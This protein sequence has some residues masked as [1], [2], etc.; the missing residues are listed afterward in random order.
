M[1]FHVRINQRSGEQSVWVTVSTVDELSRLL[2]TFSDRY[3]TAAIQMQPINSVIQMNL[4][5]Q[6]NRDP[7]DELTSLIEWLTSIGYEAQSNALVC[8]SHPILERWQ[9]LPTP[10]PSEYLF[11]ILRDRTSVQVTLSEYLDHQ[12][13][14]PQHLVVAKDWVQQVEISTILLG[15]TIGI[16]SDPRTFE[17]MVF[18][19]ELDRQFQRYRTWDEAAAGHREMV[20]KVQAEIDGVDSIQPYRD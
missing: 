14:N 4:S 15:V 10:E 18:G 1:T 5:D 6:D 17:T 11:S 19:G 7:S 20:Q 8:E 2:R 9:L 16:R 12:R 13:E 3:P